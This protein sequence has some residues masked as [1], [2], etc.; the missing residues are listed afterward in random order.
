ML[1][2]ASWAEIVPIMPL[3]VTAPAVGAALMIAEDLEAANILLVALAGIAGMAPETD[4]V[5]SLWIGGQPSR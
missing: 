2:I 1:A 4:I 3:D 5:A